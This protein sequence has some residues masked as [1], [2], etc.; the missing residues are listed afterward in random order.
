MNYADL[1]TYSDGCTPFESLI[2]SQSPAVGSVITGP[3][4]VTV[5]ILDGAGN[6]S[7]HDIMV[8]PIDVTAPV[9]SPMSD[10][11][12]PLAGPCQYLMEDFTGMVGVSDNCSATLTLSQSPAVNTPFFGHGTIVPVTI[13]AEDASGNVDSLTFN[14]E[15]EDV[16]PPSIDCPND[17][18]VYSTAASCDVFID[19][20]VAVAYDACQTV[21]PIN[22]YNGTGDASDFYG[23]GTTFLSWST[24]DDQ[25]FLSTCVQVV[26]VIDTVAPVIDEISEVVVDMFGC[27]YELG[28]LSANVMVTD[29]CSEA[30]D[31]SITQNPIGGQISGPTYLE[32][33]VTDASGNSSMTGFTVVPVNVVAPVMDCYGTLSAILPEDECEVDV[34][35]PAP[36]ATDDCGDATVVNTINGTDELILTLGL[37]EQEVTWI[38]T[39]AEGNSSECSITVIVTPEVPVSMTCPGNISTIATATDCGAEIE[40]DIPEV[41]GFCSFV[42]SN[43]FNGTDNASGYYEV[44]TSEVTF[45]ATG[46]ATASCSFT[47]EVLDITAPEMTCPAAIEQCGTEVDMDQP[48][49]NDACGI[50]SLVNDFN[51]LEDASGTYPAGET[52]IT[53]T[54]TDIS[55]NTNTCTTVVE[56]TEMDIEVDAGP[57]AILDFTFEHHLQATLPT[58]A[59]GTWSCENEDVSFSDVNDPQASVDGLALGNNVLTWTVDHGLCGVMQDEVQVLTRQYLIPTGFSPNGDNVN[60]RY[61]IR[62]LASLGGVA[63]QVFD[64]WGLEVYA[65]DEY[66]NSWDGISPLGKMLPTGTY[67]YIITLKERDE[68]LRGSLELKR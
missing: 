13:Y 49:L 11:S 15:L 16:T 3:T 63:I 39:D 8:T 61:V 30:E 45:T 25:N 21:F 23:L 37:G 60:D 10:V 59:T 65:S 41:N 52:I 66:D 47:V 20:E 54:A 34:N 31:L 24:T 35:V 55:G 43:D 2:S 5:T 51:G 58:G 40:I 9:F 64:R 27:T 29:N 53:W 44:G 38:A 68:I 14:V 1:L 17:T 42:L 56:V 28:N 67:F 57:D 22:N 19:M 48:T 36:S 50:S 7:D 12:R 26:T 6:G 4:L 46:S 18:T 32:F 62:G 33:I